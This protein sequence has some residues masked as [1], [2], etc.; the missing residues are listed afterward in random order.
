MCQDY[1]L[2]PVA[3]Y[4][5]S[6][7]EVANI[8]KNTVSDSSRYLYNSSNIKFLL[9]L[10]ENRQDLLTSEFLDSVKDINGN[11]ELRKKLLHTLD[12]QDVPP[13]RFDL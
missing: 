4:G 7:K 11:D 9:F 6:S 3:D 5:S 12:S 2:F 13:V 10:L 1:P 8:R